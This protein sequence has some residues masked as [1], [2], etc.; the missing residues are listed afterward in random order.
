MLRLL[1]TLLIIFIFLLLFY[2]ILH[3][4]LITKGKS[5]LIAG[6]ENLF[7][8][9]VYL[10]YFG[11]T[12][13]FRLKIE[14]LKVEDLL[15]VDS[16]FISLNP[17]GIFMQRLI[18]NSFRI[19]NPRLKWEIKEL[20]SQQNLPQ[21]REN[22]TGRSEKG[23]P[24]LNLIFKRIKITNAELEIMDRTQNEP[25]N[26]IIKPLNIH[27]NNLW[28]LPRSNIT[29]FE[30]QGKVLWRNQNEGSIN[31][32]GWINLYKKDMQAKLEVKCIDG[33]H[34]YPYYKN[35]VDLEKA[36][37]Q[38]AKLNLYA[39]FFS[40]NNDLSI[41]YLL[42]LTEIVRRPLKEGEA[43]E[44]AS[45]IADA[46]LG[47]LHALDKDRITLSGTIKTKL[48]KPIFGFDNFRLAF[49]EKLLQA[50]EKKDTVLENI[51]KLPRNI[52]VGTIESVSEIS[53]AIISGTLG[54]GKSI[55]EI[56]IPTNTTKKD[57]TTQDS[58]FN[59]T[60]NKTQN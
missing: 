20:S 49:E 8:R 56:F 42:E 55:K 6:L 11:L 3:L 7:Q 15:S 57:K 41:N 16:V 14:N 48:D 22:F 19:N 53:R 58:L 10:G 52:F 39:D 21:K 36:R 1:K 31:F 24:K 23:I 43:E 51:L 25:I 46:V 38:S 37:I 17:L 59:N 44:K 45:K 2:L 47:I 9:R 28:F 32:L 35:W 26:F 27:M 5:L 54:V 12:Y 40:L 33:L 34:F 13:P 18:F 60:Q 29:N 4:F 30:I 50:K